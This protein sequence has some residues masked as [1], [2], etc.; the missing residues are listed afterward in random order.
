[1]DPILTASMAA[2]AGGALATAWPAIALLH[3]ARHQLRSARQALD[4]D[5][6]T[7]LASRR[8]FT[9]HLAATLHTGQRSAVVLIDLDQF[10]QVNDRYGHHAGDAVLCQVADRL[11]ALGGDVR[12]A[13][14]LA[15]DEF[16]LITNTDQTD[17]LTERVR[18]T[19]GA[20]PYKVEDHR[21]TVTASVGFAATTDSTEHEILRTADL[22]MY[23]DK[24]AG[25]HG[26]AAVPS[27]SAAAA[28]VVEPGRAGRFRLSSGR[29]RMFP[30]ASQP[31][32]TT[33]T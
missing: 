22:S 10:K 11:R 27:G 4:H 15:G 20:T 24:A 28:R 5:D 32:G 25:R 19:I 21:V 16:A 29:R 8:A 14:R 30:V 7:G 1:M 31:A 9:T 17:T 13:A 12:L 2:A 23:Q 18:D 26:R 33:T 3:R 6:L